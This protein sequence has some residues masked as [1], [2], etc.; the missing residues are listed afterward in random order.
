MLACSLARI[1]FASD[2]ARPSSASVPPTTGRPIVTSSVV[3]TSPVSVLASSRTV[4]RIRPALVVRPQPGQSARDRQAACPRFLTLPRLRR[5]TTTARPANGWCAAVTRTRSTW[6]ARPSSVCRPLS[7]Q[8]EQ[9]LPAGERERQVAEFVEDDEVQP[10][11]FWTVSS[12]PCR[13][14]LSCSPV[15]IVVDR[16]EVCDGS[17]FVFC[18]A[19]TATPP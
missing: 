12:R 1:D 8:V 2:S 11:S 18:L 15:A 16:P 10:P 5:T 4:H 3:S 19:E 9:Q 6:R 17:S 14:G 7:Y 13:G